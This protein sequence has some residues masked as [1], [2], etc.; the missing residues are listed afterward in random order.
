MSKV[1]RPGALAGR[2]RDGAAATC[3]RVNATLGRGVAAMRSRRGVTPDFSAASASRRVAVRSS[4]LGSPQISITTR[5]SAA[6]RTASSPAW[7]MPVAF[8]ARTKVSC[9]G[10][11]P[12]SRRP[13][14][15]RP[16]VS[17]SEIGWRSQTIFRFS[18]QT[19]RASPA[20]KPAAAPLSATWAAKTSCGTPR[21]RPS[22]RMRSMSVPRARPADARCRSV[23]RPP[24]NGSGGTACA[25][26]PEVPPPR[27]ATPPDP[28]RASANRSS[29]TD[30]KCSLFVPITGRMA[31]RVNRLA[32]MIERADEESRPPQPRP[33]NKQRGVE[34]RRHDGEARRGAEDRGSDREARQEAWSAEGTI[35]KQK[36]PLE[37][38]ATGLDV[39]AHPSRQR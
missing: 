19:S 35:G 12:S 10:S 1:G 36:T 4:G 16:P 32:G 6:Q 39:A 9:P 27:G 38:W 34:C 22:P 20:T 31:S 14:A 17:R 7:R 5:P 30:P 11:S 23:F 21:G 28:R 24:R 29:M 18:A 8:L 3:H 13:G 2:G 25:R 15:C 26:S 37:P 33:G